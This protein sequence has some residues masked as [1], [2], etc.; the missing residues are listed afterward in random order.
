MRQVFFL[1]LSF[2]LLLFSQVVAQTKEQM[3]S[4]S[5]I[6]FVQG[7]WKG[8]HESTSLEAFW[9]APSGDNITGFIRMMKENKLSLYELFAFEQTPQGPVALV[10]HFKPGMVGVEEKEKADRYTFVEAGNGRVIFEKQGEVLRVLYEKRSQD[11]FAIALGKQ[12]EGKWTFK[13]LFI[14]NRIK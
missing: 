5:D 6:S 10:K 1:S 3:G 7:H 13:D 8:M 2:L 14:F 12:Q 9:T 4:L 11:Q